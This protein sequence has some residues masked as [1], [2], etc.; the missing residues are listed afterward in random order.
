MKSKSSSTADLIVIGGGIVGLATALKVMERHPGLRVVVVEKEPR[1]AAH[2]SGRNSNVIHSG[3]YYKPGSAKARLAVAGNRSMYEFCAEHSIAHARS[4]KLIVAVDDAELPRLELLAERGRANGVEAEKLDAAGVAAV[5]PGVKAEAGLRVPSAGITDFAEVCRAMAGLIARRGGE[6]LL[7][8]RV[9]RI[10]R[11]SGDYRIV[12]GQRTLV[13]PHFV[14]CAGLQ[15]DRVA[16]LE[17]IDPGILIVPFRGEY[18]HVR[19]ASLVR[20]LVYPVPDPD[21]PFLGVHLTRAIDGSL[22]AG[23]NAV[24][25]F[26]REGYRKTSVNPRD[27]AESLT[28]GGFWRM[29]RQMRRSG[30]EELRRS[31]SRKLFL[32]SVR[33]LV[34]AI[35]DDDLTPAPSGVRAQALRPDG[36]LHDDF[37]FVRGEASLHVCN[38]PSPAATASLEIG[39]HVATEL[40]GIL[41]G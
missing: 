30:I 16:R 22:H 15:S 4:G 34:P 9:R 12:A 31:F 7:E 5:E 39:A 11:R 17:G 37:L 21:L 10:E 29:A 1:W 20:A 36:S 25:A 28:Y 38:A 33:R 18:F 23:P 24:L 19:R 2:Q 13:A 6:L 40:D 32:R 41:T 35:D 8:H 14:A 27:L 3:V 26:G